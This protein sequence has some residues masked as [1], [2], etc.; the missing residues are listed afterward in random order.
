MTLTQARELLGWNRSE[1]ARKAQQPVGNIQD[2]EDGSNG[3]P[4]FSLVMAITDALREGGLKN[5]KPE[6]IFD[7]KKKAVA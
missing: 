5:L 1:L 7:P 2:I 4:S 6:D 3:N